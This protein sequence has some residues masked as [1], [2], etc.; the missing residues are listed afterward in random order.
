MPPI[1]VYMFIWS[2]MMCS[3]CSSKSRVSLY[4]QMFSCSPNCRGSIASW[5]VVWIVCP[6][7][8]VES[9][10]T[11]MDRVSAMMCFIG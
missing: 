11:M 8:I 6:C 7:S 1:G 9:I 2:L 3:K 4:M 5:A 10:P